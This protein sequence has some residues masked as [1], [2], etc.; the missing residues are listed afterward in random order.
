MCGIVGY[1]GYKTAEK[2]VLDALLRLEYRGYDSAGIAFIDQDGLHRERVVGDVINLKDKMSSFV[3][4][5]SIMIGHT[6]WATHGKVSVA[7]AHPQMDVTKNIAV[8]HNGIIE[9][10]AKLK[11]K[12]IKSGVVFESDTDTE[13]IPNLIYQK[14]ANKQFT[15]QNILISI[16]DVL[17]E[18][19][20]S[21]ALCIL[22]NGTDNM[23]VA[24]RFSPLM[25][26]FTKQGC[27]VASD[28]IGLDTCDNVYKI[29]DDSIAIVDKDGFCCY[30]LN[31]KEIALAKLN[32]EKTAGDVCC[33]PYKSFMEKEIYEGEQAVKNT[34]KM[35]IVNG[36][37]TNLDDGI[38]HNVSKIVVCACGT[39]LHAGRLFASI[40]EKSC[41]QICVVDYASEFRY[42]QMPIDKHTVCLFISQSGET[43]DTL[44]CAEL[45]HKKGAYC[46]GM[47]NV[48]TSRLVSLVDCYIPTCAGAER[49]VA[50]TKAFMAQMCALY[51]LNLKFC[52]VF[53]KK[54]EYNSTDLLKVPNVLKNKSID[55]FLCALVPKLTNLEHLYVLGRGLDYVIAMEGALKIKE[56]SYIHCESMPLGELKHGS[57]A[58]FDSNTYAIVL[59]TQSSTFSKVL[60]NICE[61]QSRGAKVVVITTLNVDIKA[62][63]CL[64]LPPTID[65][66][67]VFEVTPVLQKLALLLAES[68][69][70]NVDKPRNLAK[71][72]TVE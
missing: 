34:L 2:T 31:L 43:A 44:S 24:A 5:S 62:D 51:L 13:I 45:A 47:T 21:F 19:K 55:E 53:G 56:I 18:L 59:M 72:V 70:L 26:S 64:R 69:N 12:L 50:S 15:T 67:S 28:V 54:A 35:L 6:R 61:I 68:R 52:E 46:V 4:D 49:A 38:I 39:A 63:Y 7:N 65:C 60:N 22:L 30:D 66:L 71:S 16:R 33:Y 14:L 37:L 48:P 10:F 58:L 17:Q 8:V 20:G 32:V 1:V 27:M 9:N 41:G 40:L 3:N 25:L 42:R 29:P 11:E 36:V 23:F 57:L